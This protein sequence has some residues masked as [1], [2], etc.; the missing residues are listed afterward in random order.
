[1]R[2]ALAAIAV[3]IAFVGGSAGT[4][5]GHAGAEAS[6]VVA[7]DLSKKPVVRGEGWYVPDKPHR[8][9]FYGIALQRKC[10]DCDEWRTVYTEE[11]T[12]R[13]PTAAIYTPWRRYDC[14][15]AYRARIVAW[16]FGPKLGMHAKRSEFH[17]VRP[18]C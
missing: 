13:E 10:E 11:G 9:V 17:A 3:A 1:M 5:R 16:A 12:V 2:R 15:S 8:R 4:A 7:I 14:A 6:A 18:T